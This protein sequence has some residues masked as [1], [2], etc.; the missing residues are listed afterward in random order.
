MGTS[1][2]LLDMGLVAAYI[3]YLVY[4]AWRVRQPRLADATQFLLD[5]RRLTLPAFIATLVSTWYGG[6]LG[7][8]EYTFLHGISSW[9]V[10]GVPY[11]LAAL[12]FA[13]LLARRARRSQLLTLP[14]QLERAYG[15]STAIVGAGA[16]FIIS[17]PAA[18]VLMLGVLLQLFFGGSL[19]LWILLGTLFATLYVGTGGFRAVVHTDRI[20][21]LLMYCGFGLLLFFSTRQAGGLLELPGM[22]PETHFHPT[23]GLPVATILVW[24]VIALQTLVDPAFFQRVYAARNEVVAKK[25]ILL[26]LLL[27]FVFDFLTTATGL[28][29]RA[30]L[31]PGTDALLS[32]PLLA[33]EVL[34]PGVLGLFFV[35]LLAVIMSTVDSFSLLATQTLARDIY[36]RWRGKIDDVRGKHLRIGL[37]LSSMIAVTIASFKESV[38]GIWYDLGS[39]AT[40]MLLLPLLLSYTRSRLPQ[41]RTV[42]ISMILSGT[43]ALSWSLFAD[44]GGVYPLGL[45]PIYAGVITSGAVLLV[46]GFLKHR[47]ST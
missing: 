6:I 12:L 35:A 33:L 11:Y 37:V 44:Y 10:F 27:W 24:Y 8:G 45:Q 21:L 29:A 31:A 5:G 32:Y 15:R 18:Y 9:L 40:P 20:Q 41:N 28:Y 42:T 26:S 23:G 1:F 46:G 34:P 7:V 17:V 38:V 4:A 13:L 43:V 3:F 39:I 14:D 30:L 36:G 2:T 19:Y 47:T 25:G 22:L 16:L